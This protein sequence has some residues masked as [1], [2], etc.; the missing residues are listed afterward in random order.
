MV[1]V[2]G[3]PFTQLGD[4]IAAIS[5][6]LVLDSFVVNATGKIRLRIQKTGTSRINL[7]DIVFRGAGNPGIT[8]SVADT[9][10]TDSSGSSEA[11]LP[12]DILAGPDAPPNAGDDSNMLLGNPS[13]AQPNIILADNYLIDHKYFV[14][15]YSS[16]RGTPNWVSWHL[17]A[18]NITGAVKRQDNFAALASLP[19]NWFQVQSNSYSG[20][21]FDRGHNCPSGDRT[22]SLEANSSTFLMT[23]MIP[24][25]PRNNQGTWEKFETYIRSL[26]ASGNEAYIIMGSYGAGGTGTYGTVNT[27]ANGKITVPSRVWKIALILPS[28]TNDL[29]RINSS[30]RVI[31]INTPNENS[32]NED[33]RLYLVT[34]KDLES[35]TGHSFFSSLSADLQRALKTRKDDG[36]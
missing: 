10:L 15:A 3:A 2:N 1:S 24:Q 21:G 4:D 7:D 8:V 25:A 29:E 14:E 19:G 28:G 17:D 11:A 33:W 16:S 12:R 30:T 13:N 22:S 20:S 32:V 6:S 35:L 23:N 31:A 36:N 26:V 34:V 27:I 18:T 9:M 5:N